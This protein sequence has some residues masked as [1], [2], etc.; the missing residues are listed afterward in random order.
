VAIIQTA[1]SDVS[2]V[3][4]VVNS[5]IRRYVDRGAATRALIEQ[6]TG[7]KTLIRKSGEHWSG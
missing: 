4:G 2:L 1:A 7:G 5:I 6:K 3:L